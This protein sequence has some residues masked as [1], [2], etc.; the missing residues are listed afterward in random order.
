MFIPNEPFFQESGVHG[1]MP[2]VWY[3]VG[4]PDGDAYP[5]M[6]APIGSQYTH[7][8]ITSGAEYVQVYRKL[9][10]GSVDSDWVLGDGTGR[11]LIAQRC[12]LADFTDA[13]TTLTLTLDQSL[14]TDA[15][16]IQTSLK[17]LTGFIGDA[18]AAI[19]VGDGSTADRYNTGT[20]SV[21]ADAAYLDLGAVSGTA[22]NATAVSPKI[23]ITT[24]TDATDVTA[25]AFTIY[26]LYQV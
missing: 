10:A 20:P 23:T 4:A 15:T 7:K 17:N 24:A 1:P 16:V 21:Y 22:Y 6:Q 3:G 8:V 9:T 19:T 11:G 2:V 26:I 12:L 13:T 14:P 5:W 25:G 18:S